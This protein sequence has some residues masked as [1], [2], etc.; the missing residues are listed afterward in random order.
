MK[1]LREDQTHAIAM[2][3]ASIA[4]GCKRPLL[5]M[6]TGAGKTVVAAEIFRLARDKGKR[7]LFIVDAISLI[8]QTVKRFAEHGLHE[9]GVVQASHPLTDYSKPIQVAS[10]QTLARRQ[11]PDFDVALVDEAHRVYKAVTWLMEDNPGKV[12]AGL[13]ATP[14]TKGL[15]NLYTDLLQPTSLQHQ[16]DIGNLSPFTVYAPSH[17][18]LSGV[19]VK[20]GDYDENDLSRVM[21]DETLIADVIQTWK[22]KAD[23][24]PTLCFCVDRAHAAAMQARFQ[25]AG[26]PCGYIDGNTPREEREDV[27]RQLNNG[28]I[29]VVTNVGCLTTGIDWAV[30]CIIL[31]RP[32]KSPAL[33][34]QMIGRGLRVNPGI[35]Q[36][37]ILDHT[38]TVLR[39]GFPTDIN[40]ETLCTAKK[41]EKQKQVQQGAEPKECPAC[42]QLRKGGACP[43]GHVPANRHSDLREGSGALEML[44]GGRSEMAARKPKPSDKSRFYRELLGYCALKGKSSNFALAMFKNRFN[45]WPHRKHDV[46]P[47]NP[48]PDTLSYIRSRQIAYAKKKSA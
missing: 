48:S 46:Q 24:L 13:S 47:S 27:E 33:A 36:C 7:C 29:H 9:V 25:H 16:I 31:A 30:G 42:H 43:C 37:V 39:L 32:T 28:D 10:V 19:K 45:E 41:G 4:S 35:D 12:I 22:A 26:V 2:L 6:P 21:G 23:G 40:R 44:V 3:R 15:G 1:T 17:P 38:D 5:Q 20:A 11:V 18:D 34:V 14:W 8:D